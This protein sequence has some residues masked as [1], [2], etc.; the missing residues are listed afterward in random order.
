VKIFLS[1]SSQDR[2]K[3]DEIALA[4]QGRG[5]DVFFDK[6]SLSGG[7][8]FRSAIQEHIATADLFV[9]LITPE[10][11]RRGAYTL[12]EVKMA[13]DKWKH[14]K[15]HV[16]PVLLEPTPMGD[17]PAFLR[18]VTILEP[19]GDVA[20]EIAARVGGRHRRLTPFFVVAAGI[21]I[22]ILAVVIFQAREPK[23]SPGFRNRVDPSS[24]VVQAMIPLEAIER[25]E[26]SLDPTAG[27]PQGGEDVV[28]LERVAWGSISDIPLAISLGLAITNTTEAPVRLDL[29]PRFFQL[30]DDL[31]W[32]A[33]LLYF[34]CEVAG[35]L[36]SP[37]QRR[38]I[39]LIYDANPG[40]QGKNVHAKRIYF[41]VNGLIPLVRGTWAI[42]PLAWAE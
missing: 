16:L 11:V 27:F 30:E 10:S 21:V 36:L 39:Q 1:Y 9:F 15:K 37:G 31:G 4:L 24:F 35:D 22:V 13:R 6:A 29:T 7:E 3:A 2:T 19:E 33:E 32:K 40:W 38:Q 28:S 14:P 18:G 41:R 17:I 12:T 26:Y 34:C 23:V 20:A 5:H 25:T 42:P 8:D